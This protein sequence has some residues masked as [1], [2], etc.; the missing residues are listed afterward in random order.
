MLDTSPKHPRKIPLSINSADFQ[1]PMGEVGARAQVGHG[2]LGPFFRFVGC[3]N[4]IT[5]TITYNRNLKITQEIEASKQAREKS[6]RF[7]QNVCFGDF[8]KRISMLYVYIVV[9]SFLCMVN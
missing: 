2:A 7:Q 6:R 5:K 4:V 3:V 9:W 8:S 1:R